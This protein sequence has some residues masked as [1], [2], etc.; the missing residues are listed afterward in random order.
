MNGRL[1]PYKVSIEFRGLC[2]IVPGREIE[3]SVHQNWI[4]AFLVNAN[5]TSADNFGIKDRPSHLPFLEFNLKDLGPGFPN[6]KVT[7]QLNRDDVLLVPPEG[8][9]GGVHVS[10]KEGVEGHPGARKDEEQL[11]NWIPRM[12][13]IEPT[14]S[15]VDPDCFEPLPTANKIVARV[16]MTHG[17]LRAG[18]LAMFN[19][20][21]VVFE[22]EKSGKRQAVAGS[23]VL[24]MECLAKPFAIRL[25]KFDGT[26]R[27]ELTLCPQGETL[28]I[29]V[30]NLCME[31]LVDPAPVVSL[32]RDEDFVWNYIISDKSEE[33]D[34]L[35]SLPIPRAV[36]VGNLSLLE[37]E[38]R[39]QIQNEFEDKGG[40]GTDV[41]RCNSPQF[42]AAAASSVAAM[43][44]IVDDLSR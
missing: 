30:G 38:E 1:Q 18:A 7:W 11:F 25:R 39:R 36:A 28:N 27:K 31:S 15:Q 34:D 33:I 29:V 35:S 6:A 44:S 41:Q 43:L 9:H 8:T 23:S 32:E 22:L 5:E 19:E 14:M 37:E 26:E 12:Q 24:E 2:P 20:Q 4:G 42:D 10:F 16:H 21:P 3:E 17:R 13:S 40:G